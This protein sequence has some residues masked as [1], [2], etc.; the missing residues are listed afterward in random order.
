M[1]TLIVND[2]N[3]CKDSIASAS[4]KVSNPVAKFNMSDSFSTCPPL[5]VN[6]SNKSSNYNTF[7]WDFG[8]G[9][10]SVIPSPEHIYTYPG[11]Y[12]VKL[13]LKGYGE[14]C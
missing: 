14:L 5:Q 4:L 10:T 11:I 7:S 2:I 1:P 12:P 8:D 6:F 13:T 9:S 3:G